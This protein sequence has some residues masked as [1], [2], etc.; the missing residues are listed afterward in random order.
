MRQITAT[1]G[2]ASG[3][4]AVTVMQ[5]ARSVIVSPA[6][7]TVEVRDTVRLAAEA[8]DENGHV[9]EGAEF[10]WSSGDASVARVDGSGLVQGVGE[11]AT[12]I[13]ATAEAARG[14]RRLPPSTPTGRY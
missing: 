4:A 3:S 8:F 6:V 7:D 14:G 9:I 5:S 11:G 10:T 2:E 13:T 12:T 1:A